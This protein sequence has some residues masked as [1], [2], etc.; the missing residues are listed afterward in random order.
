MD[1]VSFGLT[2]KRNLS[3]GWFKDLPNVEI[4]GRLEL[5]HI[6][7]SREDYSFA[8]RVSQQNFSEGRKCISADISRPSSKRSDEDPVEKNYMAAEEGVN[9]VKS[10]E[11]PA[12]HT[13]VK[14]HFAMDSFIF[15]TLMGGDQLVK[16]VLQF[17][18]YQC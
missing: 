10:G 17:I 1:P 2:I 6:T 8:I 16:S 13:T 11:S 9:E 3:L 18:Y 5:V 15:D 14:F 12:I 7:L 4:L